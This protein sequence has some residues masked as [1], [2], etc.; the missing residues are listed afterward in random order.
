MHVQYV[1]VTFLFLSSRELCRYPIIKPG[2]AQGFFL[3]KGNLIHWKVF[4]VAFPFL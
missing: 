4:L 3:L 1:S 2:S